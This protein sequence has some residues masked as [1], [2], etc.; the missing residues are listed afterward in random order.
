MPEKDLLYVISNLNIG[1]PLT[2]INP[3]VKLYSSKITSEFVRRSPKGTIYMHMI[4]R[5]PKCLLNKLQ[6]E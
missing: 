6:E 2:T 5:G 3:A 4:P 1:G